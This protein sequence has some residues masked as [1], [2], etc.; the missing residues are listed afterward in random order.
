MLLLV[1]LLAIL[2]AL[3]WFFLLR[4]TDPASALSTT[5]A[6]VAMVAPA[7]IGA[8]GQGDLAG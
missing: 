4:D 3:V 6:G 1:V 5:R 2:A 7:L 8:T